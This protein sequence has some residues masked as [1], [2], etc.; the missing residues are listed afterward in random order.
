[1]CCRT[2]HLLYIFDTIVNTIFFKVAFSNYDTYTE[3]VDFCT[4]IF[5]PVAF[6]L[7]LASMD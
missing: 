2:C 5:Y 1:M 7:L 6:K 3:I 4:L